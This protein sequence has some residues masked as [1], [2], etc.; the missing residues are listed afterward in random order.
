MKLSIICAV[1]QNG[2]IGRN[3]GLPW[4]LSED[5]RYFK[6]VTMGKSIIMGRKTFESIGRPLPGRTS[7]IVTRNRSYE[8]E[9]AR[10]VDSL[11][12]AFELA[13]NISYI[14]GNDEAF[15][16]GGSELFKEALPLADRMHLTLVHADVEGDTWFPEFDPDEWQEVSRADFD[17]EDDDSYP[18]SICVFERQ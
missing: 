10:V 17:A 4:H 16:I 7:I 5:L 8:V 1:S 3:G 13:E 2:V 14:D 12:D 15:V 11:A 6:R 9:N 18:Y